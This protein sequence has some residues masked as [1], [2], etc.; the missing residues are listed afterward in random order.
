MV[1]F[2][3][4]TLR[5]MEKMPESTFDD[6][7]NKYVEKKCRTNVTASSSGSGPGEFLH[8]EGNGFPLCLR[9]IM[10]WKRMCKIKTFKRMKQCSQLFLVITAVVEV[11]VSPVGIPEEQCFFFRDVYNDAVT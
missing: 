6:I 8:Q 4:E 10:S 1:R 5:E 3:P 7:A 9:L 2:L 11:M